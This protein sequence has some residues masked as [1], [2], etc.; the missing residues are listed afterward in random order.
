MSAA[1]GAAVGDAV[2]A[3]LE[4]VWGRPPDLVGRLSAVNHRVVGKR[5][6]VTAAVF[7][8][9]A[10]IQALVMRT[11]LARSGLDLLTPEQYNQ[12]FTMHG[13]TMMFLFAVPM[14]EGLGMYLIPLMIGAR[15]MV[16]PRLNAFGYWVYLIAGVT[17]TVAFLVGRG[18]DAGWFN[19]APLSGPSFSP[20]RGID[21]W[22]TTITF[23]EV[24]ALVAA[25]EIIVTI[26]KLRAPGMTMGRAPLFVWSQLVM[27]FMILFAMPPLILASLM[28]G[29]DRMVGTHF[30]HAAAGGDPVLWQHLFWVFGHP[31]VYIILIPALGIVSSVVTVFSRRPIIGYAP[32]VMSLIAIGFL[33]FGLWVHHMFTVGLPVMGLG[34]FAAA[35]MMIAIPSGVQLFCWMATLWKGRPVLSSP[36]LY[37]L[38]FVFVFTL[39]G[40]T[41][42]MV[43]AVPFDWQVHDSHFVVAH[44]HYVLI[45]GA[46]F[47]L[48]AGFHYWYPKLSGYLPSEAVAK[49][50]FWMIF[51]GFNV[52]FFPL[53]ELGFRGM[54][55]RVYT[56]L[57]GLGWDALNLLSTA[58]AYLLG[59]GFAVFAANLVW[60]AFAG[61]RAGADPWGA[62][63][64]EWAT[65]SPPP[66]YNFE[67]IPVVR[68]R[69]PLWE[70][71]GIGPG[72][73]SGLEMYDPEFPRRETL[74]TTVMDARPEFRR[75][76][77]GPSLWP[78]VLAAAL[79]VAA[80]GSMVDLWLIP[81]GA[82]L[83]WIAMAR[84]LRP[85]RAEEAP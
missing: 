53:H 1:G 15:D 71:G 10:G 39:G 65:P 85:P 50:A 62:D 6:M 48:L 47:P 67:R 2:R 23:L 74:A 81:I 73:I 70:A 12:F 21:F 14:M 38:G 83:A 7:F 43:A 18:P 84:W 37:V 77:P 40:L 25:V 44:F 36:L 13:T 28:L 3:G 80:I 68:G 45:G 29:L 16:F 75:T 24:A 19:Y 63:S 52:A 79:A 22:V 20:G 64:L 41:G 42:V 26:L 32:I 49:V 55:R 33:S 51:I 59:L 72:A 56:Y 82:V 66:V 4:R 57:P 9:L 11:Q 46:V 27:A 58:G 60:S 8:F 17:L 35:S 31:E 61:R 69:H 5:Y 30:F 34:F 54:P 76:L 78:L